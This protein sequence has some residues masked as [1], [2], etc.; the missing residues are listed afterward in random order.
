MLTLNLISLEQKKEIKQKRIFEIIKKIFG[1]LIIIFSTF[2]IA[3]L[4]VKLALQINFVNTVWST[5]LVSKNSRGN[6]MKITDI[7]RKISAVSNIQNDFRQWSILI[8]NLANTAG[9]GISFSAVNIDGEKKTIIIS[10]VAELR[11]DL[12]NFKEKLEK[13]P[14]FRDVEFPMQNILQKENISFEIKAKLNL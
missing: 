5:T 7:N 10:G 14:S 6:N 11:E 2:A 8:E 4:L 12:L 13:S 9:Q 1:V 3:L